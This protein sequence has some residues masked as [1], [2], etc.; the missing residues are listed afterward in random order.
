MGI[1]LDI[2]GRS[3]ATMGNLCDVMGCTTKKV[4]WACLKWDI[5]SPKNIFLLGQLMV[6]QR[7]WGDPFLKHNHIYIYEW[8][9][10]IKLYGYELCYIKFNYVGSYYILL[11]FILF[12]HTVSALTFLTVL[13]QILSTNTLLCSIIRSLPILYPLILI[14]AKTYYSIL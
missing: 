2:V 4:I 10:S 6:D 11:C 8:L 9:C 12:F 3:S 5:S 1:W 14:H 13:Y 7:I